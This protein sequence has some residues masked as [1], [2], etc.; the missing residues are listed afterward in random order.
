MRL[1]VKH[2]PIACP[3]RRRVLEEYLTARGFTDV[4][5]VTKYPVSHPFVQWLHARL[6]KHLSPSC[7]SGLVKHLE[8]CLDLVNDPTVDS[9]ILC[10]DDVVFL[11][12]WK[13][14]LQIPQGAPFV[15]V[16]VGVNYQVYPDGQLRQL[17][18]NG[19]CEAV[20]MTKEFARV[21]LR[22]VDARAGIDHVYFALVRALGFPLLCSPIAQQTSSLEPRKSSLEISEKYQPPRPWYEYVSDFKPTRLDYVSL[23]NESQIPRDDS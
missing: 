6:G 20:W 10:D 19:G 4:K 5:W 23:W 7:I 11:K 14:K 8:A 12:D 1:Y 17:N 16:S 2:C 22:N 15:N 9:A 18:N 3:D 13:E 21:V